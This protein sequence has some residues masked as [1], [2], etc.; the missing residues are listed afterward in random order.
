M[1]LIDTSVWIDFLRGKTGDRVKL[2]ESLLEEGEAH[3]CEITYAEICF[4]AKNQKQHDQYAKYFGD[5]PFLPLPHD[6]HKQ[7]AH[8]GF[9]VRSKGFKPF[10]ADLAIALTA[11]THKAALLTHDTDF[12]I[13]R[14]LFGLQTA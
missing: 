10:V 6:W 1:H 14:N 9:M 11:L 8:M 7:M 5:L 12:E 3:L 2:L 4:G 13:Y